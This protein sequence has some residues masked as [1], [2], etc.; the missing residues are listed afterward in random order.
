M[1]RK[2]RFPRPPGKKEKPRLT[3]AAGAPKKFPANQPPF[4][5]NETE[6]LILLLRSTAGL[7]AG[8]LQMGLMLAA[9]TE[10]LKGALGLNLALQTLESTI[11]RLALLYLDFWHGDSLLECGFAIGGTDFQAK[12]PGKERGE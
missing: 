6:L 12:C 8:A 5:G 1:I 4:S 10:F 9:A 7:P 2:A 11:D 3:L